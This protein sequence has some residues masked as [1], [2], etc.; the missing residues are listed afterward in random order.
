MA[1]T[2]NREAFERI[3]AE[4]LEWLRKQPRSLERDHIELLL[5]SAPGIY[6]DELPVGFRTWVDWIRDRKG[7]LLKDPFVER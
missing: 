2:L 6:Y 1:T 7:S 5:M 4:N 3:C